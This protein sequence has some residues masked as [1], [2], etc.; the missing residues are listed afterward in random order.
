MDKKVERIKVVDVRVNPNQPRKHFSEASIMELAQSIKENGLIQPI[1]VRIKDN[2]Y[3]L[4][5]GERRLRA[6]KYLSEQYIDAIVDNVDDSASSKLSI[7]ENIQRENLSAIEEAYAYLKLLDNYDMTQEELA[8]SIGKSQSSIANKIRLL[9]LNDDMQKS[10]LNKE[11]TERHGRALLKIKDDKVREEAFE[12]IVNDKMNVAQTDKYVSSLVKDKPK[13]GKKI[14]SKANY[15]VE[16]NTIKEALALI[17]KFGTKTSINIDNDEHG[18]RIV[19][20]LRK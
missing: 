12:K 18:V 19:I 3:E 16:I 5:A 7:I 17:E 15:Q 1:I 11:I 4:I 2:H 14:I 8:K 20:E 6:T 10:I 13:K 9:G